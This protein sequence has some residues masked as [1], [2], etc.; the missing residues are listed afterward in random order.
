MPGFVVFGFAAQLLLI[1]FFAAHLW[2]PARELVFGRLVYGMGLVALVL[3]VAFMASGQ[4]WYLTLA[5]ALYAV[6]SAG[7]ALVDHVFPVQ[8]RE[9]PRWSILIPYAAL[10]MAALLA[11]WVPLWWVDRWLWIA[12]GVLNATHTLLNIASHRAARQGGAPTG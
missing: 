6:W 8:W 1:G 5:L 10:L 2:R 7:G 3:A 4:P 11:L 12:F 9:P